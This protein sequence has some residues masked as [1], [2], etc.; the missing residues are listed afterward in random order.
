MNALAQPV[1]RLHKYSILLLLIIFSGMILARWNQLY[2]YTPDSG[3][4]VTMAKSLVNGTGYREIDTPGEPLYSHR[5]PGMSVLLA[6][7][8]LIAPYNVLVAKATVWLSSLALLALL[9]FYV[10]CLLRPDT[11]QSTTVK[12]STY[13]TA[14]LITGLLAL[15]PYTLLFSTLVMSEIPFMVCSL[16]ILY[17]LAIRPD[18]PGKGQLIIFTSLLIFL[19]FLR[20][21]G[22]AMILATGA[23]AIFRNARWRWLIGVF[24]SITASGM[25]MIRN[26][27]IGRTGY[28]SIALGEFKSQ[29]IVGTLLRMIERITSH[30]EHLAQ[31]LFP[32]L[33]GSQPRYSAMILDNITYLPGPGWLYLFLAAVVILISIYGMLNCRRKGGTVALGY[34]VLS[35]AVLSLWPWIQPRF[36]FPLLPIVL[37]YLPA[38]YIAFAKHFQFSRPMIRSILAG[39]VSAIALYFGCIQIKTD[40]QL[41]HANVQML[42]NPNHFYSHQMPGS[43]FSHWTAAGEWINQNSEEHSRIMARQSAT[44]TTAQRYQKL[45]YFDLFTAETLHKA[46][47]QFHANYLVTL[48]KNHG[49]VFSW[50]LMDEDLVYRLNPV[51]DERGIMVI[52]IEPNRSGTIREKYY[53]ADESLRFARNAYKKFPH[54]SNLQSELAGELFNSGHYEEVIDFLQKLQQKNIKDMNLT[55]LLGWSY[56]KTKQYKKA[57]REF[58]AALRMP[59]QKLIRG[60]LLRGIHTAQKA[61]AEE[62]STDS[63][64]SESTHQS[65]EKKLK[66]A[67]LYWK[68]YQINKAEQ[69]LSKALEEGSLQPE[70]HAELCTLLAKVYLV[71][72]NKPAAVE[73]LNLAVTSGGTEAADILKMLEREEKVEILLNNDKQNDDAKSIQHAA[74]ILPDILTLVEW[75]QEFGVPGKA[76]NL[77]ER[78][79]TSIPNQPELLKLLLQKQLFYSLVAEAEATLIQLN[80]LTSDDSG[81]NEAA[82]QIKELQQLPRF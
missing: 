40:Y 44:A 13:W 50:Y 25:W 48:N 17:V 20:T 58:E 54:R 36:T 14:L 61:L 34:L 41:I 66:T 3:R 79:N 73:Q 80:K 38:G 72:E 68:N 57:I 8:A 29:G 16:A 35:M 26:S 22:I 76:L 42:T 60:N 64:R 71:K 74:E 70:I 75:Y 32:N 11:E 7:A 31:Q 77:L 82:Q 63:K 24:C 46:I 28:T 9:Y 5:P 30:F 15:N 69:Y 51:Y 18:H 65:G 52:K 6:P 2:F 81:L 55:F 12:T 37:A 62:H 43:A 19:P 1:P 56:I 39:A 33:P 53:S 45:A 78:A 4:Y 49:L 59:G 67:R 23:W 21:I 10:I 47:Q 27:S